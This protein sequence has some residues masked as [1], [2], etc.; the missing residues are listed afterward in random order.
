MVIDVNEANFDD[1][2]RKA[3]KPVLLWFHADWCSGCRIVSPIFDRVA[4]EFYGQI[5]PCRV[6]V[7][8]SGKLA[9]VFEVM[10]L[11]AFRSLYS[12]RGDMYASLDGVVSEKQLHDFI[13]EYMIGN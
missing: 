10:T 3:K 4:A 13:M 6:D 9:E 1:V 7:G 11:P 12:G 2:V 8:T 5:V